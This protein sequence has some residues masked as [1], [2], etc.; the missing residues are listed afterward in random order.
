[1]NSSL[2]KDFIQ[3]H[4]KGYQC[5]TLTVNHFKYGKFRFQLTDSDDSVPDSEELLSVYSSEDKDFCG[6]EDE[7]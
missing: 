7:D 6:F 2:L 1:V 5:H 3:L 4:N